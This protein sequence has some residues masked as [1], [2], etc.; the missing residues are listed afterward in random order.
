LRS[1]SDEDIAG[2]VR[3]LPQLCAPGATVIW[4]H[5][6]GYLT[7]MSLESVFVM[8]PSTGETR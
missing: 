3:A 8:L 4:T 1:I 2:T 7:K 6:D 5:S